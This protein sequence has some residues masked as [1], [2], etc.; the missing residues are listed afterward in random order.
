MGEGKP[1][2]VGPVIKV[3]IEIPTAGRV[4]RIPVDA[5]PCFTGDRES[6][7]LH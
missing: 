5:R 6:P 4:K 2:A 1:Q 7:F 3:Y